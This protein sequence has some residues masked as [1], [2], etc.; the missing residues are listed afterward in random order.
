MGLRGV[1]RRLVLQI[2][3][4]S[5]ALLPALVRSAE[6]EP[7]L[8]FVIEPLTI[9]MSA[10]GVSYPELQFMFNPENSSATFQLFAL[11]T[12]P[13]NQ[14]ERVLAAYRLRSAVSGGGSPWQQSFAEPL[15]N[16]VALLQ[17]ITTPAGAGLVSYAGDT[18]GLLDLTTA[19]FSS[20]LKV[21]SIYRAQAVELDAEVKIARDLTGDGLD[22]LLLPDFSGW[23]FSAALA[24]GGFAKAQLFGPKPLMNVGSARYVNFTAHTPFILD[25]NQDGLLDVAFWNEGVLQVYQQFVGS[26][27]TPAFST[28]AVSLAVAPNI[29]T[30]AFFSLSVGTDEDNPTGR[31]VLLDAIEDLDA[32]GLPDMVVYSV[33]G[34][35]LFGKETRYEIHRGQLSAQ[36]QL[37][38]ESEPSSLIGS[39]GIQIDVERRDLNGDGT[40][41]MLVTSFDFGIGSIIRGLLSRSAN[42]QLAIYTMEAGRYAKT[43][44]LTRKVTAKLDIAKGDIFVPAVLAGD[45]DGDGLKDLLVQDGDDTL[46]VFKGQTG[47][48][49][50]AR[51]PLSLDIELPVG[52][53]RVR[54]V[55]LD[56]DS[57]DD[58]LVLFAANKSQKHP[59]RVHAVR[60]ESGGSQ[61]QP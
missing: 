33:T 10:Q 36:N 14:Q 52:E 6:Q 38:F 48:K 41:E 34:D 3:A 28:E 26:D 13:A 56:G 7:D 45:I 46:K 57:D 59:P 1:T 43:P 47:K 54:V 2:V 4:G 24:D 20:L 31:Q 44:V 9:D 12:N 5:L 32:D 15:D 18:V 19:R 17:R 42:L 49:P 23:Q 30:D 40:L 37:E 27:A 55:N 61:V 25:L 21:A 29:E 51:S 11:G 58:L 8:G 60:F 16:S 39:G 53:G 50:F 35:G 22:D